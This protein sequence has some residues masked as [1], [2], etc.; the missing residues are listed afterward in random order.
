MSD[1]AFKQGETTNVV[2]ALNQISLQLAQ[3]T[4]TVDRVFPQAIGTALSVT[5]G[6]ITPKNYVGYLS[7][8]NPA[9]GQNVEIGYYSPP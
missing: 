9:S 3:L 4:K 8:Y 6:S 5:S 2:N 1:D 7:V